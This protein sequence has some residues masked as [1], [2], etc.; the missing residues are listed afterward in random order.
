[1]IVDLFQIPTARKDKLP[2]TN[3]R[4]GINLV[5][6]MY[7][8]IFGETAAWLLTVKSQTVLMSKTYSVVECRENLERFGNAN[9]LMTNLNSIYS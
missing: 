8:C 1:M 4:T 7:S 6:S 5:P 9:Q 2:T 3:N